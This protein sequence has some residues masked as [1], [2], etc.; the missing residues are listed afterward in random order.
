MQYFHT[1]ISLFVGFRAVPPK[2]QTP[3][4]QIDKSC[5][6]T[7]FKK[8][9]DRKGK[10]KERGKEGQGKGKG[11]WRKEKEQERGRES[12]E[13]EERKGQAWRG[14]D[15]KRKGGVLNMHY[16]ALPSPLLSSPLLLFSSSPLLLFSS[17][18]LL[19]FSS[20]PLLLFSSSPLL[21]FSSS[22]LLASPRLAFLP[23][24][25]VLNIT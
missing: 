5:C 8:G 19:L 20:S 2:D 6:Q 3:E 15:T 22:P 12:E 17:S 1:E 24:T 21:L 16:A 4:K 14:K 11:E 23:S 7:Q 9:H 10:G 13:K 25:K 18:P